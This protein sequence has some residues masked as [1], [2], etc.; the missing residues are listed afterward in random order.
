MAEKEDSNLMRTQK[1]CTF[2]K[3]T[4]CSHEQAALKQYLMNFFKSNR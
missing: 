4:A 3:K 1:K 2:S